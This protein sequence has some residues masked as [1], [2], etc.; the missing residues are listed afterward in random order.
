[1]KKYSFFRIIKEIDLFGKE[2]DIYY[3][4]KKRKTTWIGRILSWIFIGFY[5]FFFIYKLVRMFKR[6]DVNFSETN[7]STGGLPSIHLDKEVFTYG[8]A[9]S[10]ASGQPV[11]D[12]TIYVPEVVFTGAKTIHGKKEQF[13]YILPFEKCDINDFGE[14]FKRFTSSMDLTKYYCLKN[15]VVFFEGYTAAE[16]FSTLI[17]NIKKCVNKTRDG[18]PC[19]NETEI[20]NALNGKNLIIFS[21]D[22]DLT[23]NDYEKPVKEKFTVNSCP[24]R[25][26]QYQTFIGY[27]QLANIQTERNLFGFEAFSDI[28][29]EKYI[30][31]HSALIMAYQMVEGQQDVMSYNFLLKE[32]TLTN[33]RTY[34]QLIDVLGDVGGLMEVIQSIFGVICALVADILYDK[35]MVNNLF[36]F[37]LNNFSIKIKNKPKLNNN[38]LTQIKTSYLNNDKIEIKIDKNNFSKNTTMKSGETKKQKFKNF[39]NQEH[40][41]NIIHN[42]SYIEKATNSKNLSSQRTLKKNAFNQYKSYEENNGSEFKFEDIKIYNYESPVEDKVIDKRKIIKKIKTNLFCT[43]FCFCIVRKRENFGNALLDEAMNIIT[44]KLDIYNMFRNFYFI[45]ELKT[46]W[47][48]EYKDFEMSDECKSKLKEVSKKIMDSF[49]RL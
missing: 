44:E 7:D 46:N 8:L 25:L 29:S 9:L 15:F 21:E 1:M 43:Y 26:D 10:D 32:N 36:T 45:D 17:I 4:G 6:L 11:F 47:N 18:R 37:D 19:K 35:T 27:Y 41:N 3:K 24:I 48:Y 28:K 22:F 38:K 33:L 20:Y 40:K 14:N 49:Y 23:P 31:Y 16:N 13:Y 12:E 5:I 34:T 39:F 2:P 30:I 42:D